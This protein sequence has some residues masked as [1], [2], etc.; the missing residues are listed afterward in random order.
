MEVERTRS[1]SGRGLESYNVSGPVFGCAQQA[2]LTSP[3]V[4]GGVDH[5]GPSL[6]PREA[7]LPFSILTTTAGLTSTSP[8]AISSI[9]IGPREKHRS[10]I[11]T[12]TTVTALL[13]TSP[14]SRDW[15]VP[16]GRPAFAWAITTTTDG[17]ILFCCFWGHNILFRNNGDGTFTDVTHKAGPTGEGSLGRGLHLPRL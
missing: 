17:T 5:K 12:K 8:M 3:N 4:W 9:R 16:A 2:G 7:D 15:A 13:Q 11:C 6:R 10:R 1:P 14:K